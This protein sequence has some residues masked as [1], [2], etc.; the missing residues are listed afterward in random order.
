MDS[1]DIID[2]TKMEIR[3]SA[4]FSE[5]RIK[6]VSQKKILFLSLKRKF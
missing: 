3:A 6:M 4:H 1:Q 2:F 5:I